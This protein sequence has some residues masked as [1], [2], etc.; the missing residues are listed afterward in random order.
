MPQ[1]LSNAVKRHGYQGVNKGSVLPPDFT[2][3]TA[4]NHIESHNFLE[5]DYKSATPAALTGQ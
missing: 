2:F 4:S 5:T 3:T 1:G